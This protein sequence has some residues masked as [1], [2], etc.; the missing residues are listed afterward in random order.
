MASAIN[1]LGETPFLSL[2]AA[3]MAYQ[4]IRSTTDWTTKGFLNYIR[5]TVATETTSREATKGN[6][7]AVEIERKLEENISKKE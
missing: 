4:V 6:R 7:R 1:L 2:L 3:L 5:N